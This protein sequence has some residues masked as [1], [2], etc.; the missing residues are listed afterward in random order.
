MGISRIKTPVGLEQQR[1]RTGELLI[2][3][4]DGQNPIFDSPD[5]F[6]IDLDGGF[7]FEFFRNGQLQMLGLQYIILSAGGVGVGLKLFRP[8][9]PQ[10]DLMIN[11]VTL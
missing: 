9:R 1:L 6:A 11:Y 2:G 5:D 4:K 8:P 7:Y 3:V 10:E